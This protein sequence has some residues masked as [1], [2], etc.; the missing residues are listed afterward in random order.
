MTGN[1][2]GLSVFRV[3]IV[4]RIY[5]IHNTPSSWSLCTSSVKNFTCFGFF[6]SCF[7]SVTTSYSVLFVKKFFCQSRL[8]CF[9][10]VL[11]LFCSHIFYHGCSVKILGVVLSMQMFCPCLGSCSVQT[12]VLST[13]WK[14]FRVEE[15]SVQSF[16]GR[17]ASRK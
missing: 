11:E 4:N 2:L 3:S 9:L 8:L 14:L 15:I 7:L 1:E 6:V 16:E 12:D 17:F 10:C 5:L 13:F